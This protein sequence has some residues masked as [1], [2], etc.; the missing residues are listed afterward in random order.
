MLPG[1]SDL[2]SKVTLESDRS[3]VIDEP[4]FKLLV[5]G[6]WSGD[7]E[8]PPPG[9][10]RPL[11]I[12][13]DNF[14]QIF[15][16]ITPSLNLYLSGQNDLKLSFPALDDF[17]PDSLF[18]EVPIFAELR[19]LRSG[20]LNPDTF[21]ETASR[22]RSWAGGGQEIVDSE[23]D[24]ARAYS[25]P[26]SGNLLDD[27]L[28][29]RKAGVP[30]KK[31][32]GELDDLLG[33]LV[34]P[35]LVKVDESEQAQL[36]AAVDEATGGMMRSI[37]HD[38][39][40]QAL[41]A[42][43]RGLYFLIRN[44]E[45]GADLKIFVL[46]I[47]QDEL[48]EGLRSVGDLRE[49]TLF[50]L[51]SEEASGPGSE[52]YSA[53]IGNYAFLPDKDDIAGLIRLARVAESAGAPFVAHMRPDVLGVHT[54]DGKANPRDWNTDTD[55]DHGKLW[56]ALRSLPESQFLGLTIPRFLARLPYGADTDASESFAFEEF[57]RPPPPHD[58]YLWGNSCFAAGLLLARSF[59]AS[60]WEM[61]RAL[62]QDLEGLPVHIYKNDGETLVQPCAEVQLTQ[63]ACERLMEYGLMPL[64]SYKNSDRVKLARFQSVSDPVSALRGPWNAE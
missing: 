58:D 30:A 64:V 48:L 12:D 54:L 44:A 3:G 6:D 60:G 15:A 61:G 36:I 7:G 28:S 31:R 63:D 19:E 23:E 42:A 20:L 34:R 24:A 18:K 29:G 55:S 11:E 53:I 5:L 46:N 32:S 26:P 33:E 62:Q 59:A 10:R 56:A 47:S 16:K 41:E 27:I 13:R 35:H 8:K 57:D 38:R 37:I 21:N 2:E 14:D 49:S 40:F 50:R 1:Q 45:T 25:E 17:H 43:W 4:P 9:E 39:R 51:V 22:V 52:P